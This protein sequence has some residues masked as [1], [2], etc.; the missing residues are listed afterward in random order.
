MQEAE[1]E[2]SAQHT[3][4]KASTSPP[5]TIPSPT[6]STLPIQPTTVPV[7]PSDRSHN[8]GGLGE[9]T[10]EQG[11]HTP[12]PH[13]SSGDA[14]SQGTLHCSYRVPCYCWLVTHETVELSIS[15][16]CTKRIVL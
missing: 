7:V 15:R 2:A 8:G 5:P 14:T 11:L 16:T 12:L 4:T 10:N 9:N 1:A 6:L 3:I 13:I